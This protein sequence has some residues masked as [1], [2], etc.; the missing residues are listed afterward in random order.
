M[1]SR[2]L[3]WLVI[4]YRSEVLVEMRSV[5]G[6]PFV[7]PGSVREFLYFADLVVQAVRVKP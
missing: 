2:K 4:A 6:T 7:N 3:F 1:H 5:V